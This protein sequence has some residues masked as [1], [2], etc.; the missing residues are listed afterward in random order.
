M[1]LSWLRVSLRLAISW[2]RVFSLGSS[3]SRLMASRSISSW[4]I[5]RSMVSSS[6]G[7]ELISR[8]SL[9]AASSMRS[10]ALSG[11]KRLE[12]YLWESSTAATMASSLIRTW[13]YI[14]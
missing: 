6:S 12:M 3:F 11:R 9:E 5:F 14:S 7:A 10:M 1:A 8:R 2:F 4:R 13:W